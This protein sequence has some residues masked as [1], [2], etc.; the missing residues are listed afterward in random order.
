[1]AAAA[2]ISEGGTAASTSER[3][4]TDSASTIASTDPLIKA[5][6]YT[7]DASLNTKKHQLTESVTMHVVNNTDGEVSRLCIVNTAYGYLKYDRKYYK[8][9]VK[10]NAKTSIRGISAGG[11][12]LSYKPG[13]DPSDLFVDLGDS[14]LA[15]GQSI[16]VTVKVTTSVPKREDRFGYTRLAGGKTLYNLS[17]CFPY[18]SDYRGGK[19]NYH[20]YYDD[21]ENRNSAVSDYDITFRAP[22]SYTVAAVGKSSTEDGITKIHAANVREMAICASDAYKKQSWTFNGTRVNNYYFP[23]RY[24][25]SKYMKLYNKVCKSVANESLD[26]YTKNIGPYAYDE[27][28]LV[29]CLFGFGFGGMEYPGLAMINGNLEYY[30]KK[31]SQCN[32]DSLRS[33]VTH[34]IAHQWFYAAVGSDEYAE[35]WLDEGPVSFLETVEFK[36]ADSSS[37]ALVDKIEKTPGKTARLRKEYFTDIRKEMKKQLKSGKKTYVNVPVN[38]YPKDQVTSL[39]PYDYGCRFMGYLYLAMGA[40]AF[41]SA[42]HDYYETYSMKQATTEDF[43]NVIRRHDNA[44]KVN[45]IIKLFVK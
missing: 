9:D 24:K 11:K 10:K 31:Q 38:K 44:E 3:T 37:S 33:N 5:D 22:K 12:A 35:A 29:E 6:H 40:D 25:K 26:L 39:I 23:G 1:M 16:D 42:L 15:P 4:A 34:E 36:L 21:G 30:A 19:W 32:F 14:R 17:F 7:I 45:A 20:P 18:L 41:H 27:L 8:F 28:D 13:K 2:S 43:V